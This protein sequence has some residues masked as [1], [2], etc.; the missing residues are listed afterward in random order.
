MTDIPPDTLAMIGVE[1][2]RTY[3]VTRKDIK[4]FAQA[5]DDPNP[6]FRDGDSEHAA[7]QPAIVAP[8]LFCQAFAFE[9]VELEAL[10]PDGS[11]VEINIPLPAEKTVGG[12]SVFEVFG[13]IRSGDRITVK[14][15]VA[16]V[17]TKQGRSGKLF[18]VVVE[19]CFYN[20]NDELVSKETATFIKR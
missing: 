18:F 9:D 8:P 4:R 15:K 1:K 14:S 3:E 6:K 16:D 20:Q 19:S 11:P 5:I 12:G 2:V 10:P 17:Y 13:Q 7:V